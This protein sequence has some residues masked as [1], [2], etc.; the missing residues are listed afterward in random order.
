MIIENGIRYLIMGAVLMTLSA[1]PLPTRVMAQTKANSGVQETDDKFKVDTYTKFIEN[2][3][4][5]KAVAYDTAKIYLARY[6]KDNDQYSKYISLWVADYEKEQRLDELKDLVYQK[7]DF[8]GAFKLGK[9]VIAESPDNLPSL[10]ALGNAGYLAAGA[11]NESY[12]A[13]ALGYANKAIQLIDSGKTPDT[14][15]PFKGKD[16]TLAYLHTTVGLL[17]LKSAPNEAIDAFIKTAQLN[18]ELSKVPLTYYYLALAY[19]NG[20]YA[21][22]SADYQ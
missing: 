20:P 9:Q 12:N 11:K 17:K 15:A 5:N 19:Q 6:A 4:T 13:E 2:Y 21:K 16:D 18:S 3:K 8:A 14:W 7:R 1:L 10:I 22:L